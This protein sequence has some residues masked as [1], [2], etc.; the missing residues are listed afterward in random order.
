MSLSLS[1]THQQ[2]SVKTLQIQWKFL[3]KKKCKLQNVF[4]LTER[5][6]QNLLEIIAPNSTNALEDFFVISEGFF[7]VLLPPYPSQP[8]RLQRIEEI[9]G[10]WSNVET[11]MFQII[12]VIGNREKRMT[13]LKWKALIFSL[14]C[15]SVL[16]VSELLCGCTF[17][18][19]L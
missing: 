5:T 19:I 9:S 15:T 1:R 14:S 2:L 10:L 13:F 18:N 7:L 4:D 3:R 16:V 11:F 6:W 8:R 17:S 12:C